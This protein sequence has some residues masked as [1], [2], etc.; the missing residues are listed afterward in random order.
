MSSWAARAKLHLLQKAHKGSDE[1]DESPFPSK[2]GSAK[3][4]ETPLLALMAPQFG[5]LCEKRES[6]ND[7]DVQ[8]LDPATGHPAPDNAVNWHVTD[9]AYMAHHFN[10]KT[11]IAAGRGIRYGLRCGTGDALWALYAGV[12][13]ADSM[14]TNIKGRVI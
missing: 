10:C 2:N 9:G 5:A 13:T 1:S 7:C 6:A 8:A 4:D 12:S 11:C 3:S 14:A